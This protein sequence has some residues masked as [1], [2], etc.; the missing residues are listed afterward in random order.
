MKVRELDL[1]GVYLFEPRV[2]VDTRGFFMETWHATRY[3]QAQVPT[4]FVQ[5]NYSHSTRGVLRGLHYQLTQPQGK[6]V[7]V[8]HGEVYDVA[9]DIRRGSPTFGR[10]TGVVLSAE[11]HYQL[12]IP[13]GFA[14][15]FC[16]L[17]A[18]ADFLYKCTAFYRPEDEY[19]LHWQDPHLGI[20]WPV[21]TPLVSAKDQAYPT[22]ATI[23][24]D[25]L[26][27]FGAPA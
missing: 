12:Y 11:N 20:H 24:P 26:P 7:W 25:H 8:L 15:G 6:L 18:S 5:D 2:F 19:G 14:H 1:A 27:R 23:P 21:G 3:Q 4:A 17:S 10:W 16:V 13:P 22:L 9:V